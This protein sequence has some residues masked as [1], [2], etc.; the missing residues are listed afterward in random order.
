MF[1]KLMR[2]L[3]HSHSWRRMTSEQDYGNGSSPH[4]GSYT[5]RAEQICK[6]CGI[7]RSTMTWQKWKYELDDAQKRVQY[8]LDTEPSKVRHDVE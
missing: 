5:G 4:W 2:C 7:T 1:D 8:L 6:I 3:P